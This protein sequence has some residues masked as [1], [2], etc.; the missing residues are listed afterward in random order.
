MKI[1]KIET[2]TVYEFS[3]TEEEVLTLL[4]L[5]YDFGIQIGEELTKAQQRLYVELL[6]VYS[7]TFNPMTDGIRDRPL[8]KKAFKSATK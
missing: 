5:T 2:P 4:W 1:K 7:K 6:K 3:L 8:V